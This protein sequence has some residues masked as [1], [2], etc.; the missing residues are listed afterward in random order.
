VAILPAAARAQSGLS[1]WAGLGYASTE[2]NVTLG[3]SAKQIGVQLALPTIPLAVRGDVLLFGGKYE[4]DALSF[5]ANAVLQMR[6]RIFQPYAIFGIGRYATSL[7]NKRSG[8][9]YGAG[10]RVGLVRFGVFTEYRRHAPIGR[11]VTMVGV[12]F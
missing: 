11:N 12:T 4:F 10:L 1:V 3:K 8:S 5:N 9:N 6:R 2:G 7:T